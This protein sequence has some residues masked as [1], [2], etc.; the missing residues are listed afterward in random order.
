MIK[1]VTLAG[2]TS[3]TMMEECSVMFFICKYTV[4]MAITVNMVKRKQQQKKKN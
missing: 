4:N 3:H 1:A 2:F